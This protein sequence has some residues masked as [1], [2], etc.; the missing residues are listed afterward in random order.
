MCV[1]ACMNVC[2]HS[3][4][5]VTAM[6]ALSASEL[7]E[8]ASTFGTESG[9]ESGKIGLEQLYHLVRSLNAKP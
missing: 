6:E 4:T 5:Q 3:H 7:K 9:T 8:A 1:Y 2:A